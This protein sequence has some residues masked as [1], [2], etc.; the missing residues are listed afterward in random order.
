MGGLRYARDTPTTGRRE[1][2][3]KR[4]LREMVA[5]REGYARALREANAD[6]E[7]RLME[8]RSMAQEEAIREA[9]AAAYEAPDE[10]DFPLCDRGARHPLV[11]P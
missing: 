8:E 7:A 4:E 3:T 9:E 5:E 1:V 11:E 10:P 6:L 2:T